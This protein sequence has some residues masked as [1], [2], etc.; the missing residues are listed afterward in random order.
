MNNFRKSSFSKFVSVFTASRS[1]PC[2]SPLRLSCK[3]RR[4]PGPWTYC[5]ARRQA[6]PVITPSTSS[7]RPASLPLR[8]SLSRFLPVTGIA[9]LVGAGLRLRREHQQHMRRRLIYRKICRKHFSFLCAVLDY[10]TSS[11]VVTITSGGSSATVTAGHCVRLKIGLERY[12]H[13]RF[14]P[15]ARTRSRTLSLEIIRSPSAVPSATRALSRSL[16]TTATRSA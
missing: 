13:H 15:L 14:R 2:S 1:F 4:S 8:T 12:R 6:R 3:R 10:R 5:H 9:S 7:R 16:S 11:T